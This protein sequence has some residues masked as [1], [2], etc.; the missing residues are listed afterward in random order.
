M[1]KYRKQL[2]EILES[3]NAQKDKSKEICLKELAEKIGAS[4]VAKAGAFN[5]GEAELV[6][7]I[8]QALQTATMINMCQT[9]SKNYWIAFVAALVALASAIA[10]WAATNGIQ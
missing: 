7:N 2:A 1:K 3:E 4:T 9:A 5:P 10:A 8:H 6:D